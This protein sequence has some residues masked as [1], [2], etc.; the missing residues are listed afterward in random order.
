MSGATSVPVIV[1]EE[2]VDVWVMQVGKSW[3][4]HATFRGREIKG[5]GSSQ[6]SAVSDWRDRANYAANE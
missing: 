3:R 1:D 6:S 5:S 2:T 4:A